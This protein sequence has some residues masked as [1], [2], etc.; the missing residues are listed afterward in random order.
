MLRNVVSNLESMKLPSKH[1]GVTGETTR[2]GEE[3][4]R[5][6]PSVK[7]A[8]SV[9]F[10]QRAPHRT[11]TRDSSPIRR[12][13]NHSYDRDKEPKQGQNSDLSNPGRERDRG[14]D[15][16]GDHNRTRDK[17]RE[18]DEER[19]DVERGKDRRQD[20]D[21]RSRDNYRS[22]DRRG[23]DEGSSRRSRSRSR[24][25]SQSTHEYGKHN[26]SSHDP[27][28]RESKEKRSASSNL[29]E[30]KDL[31]GVSEKTE[32]RPNRPSGTEEVIRLGGSSWR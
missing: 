3:T 19:R 20:Y 1:C 6:P 12:S 28:S 2:G 23:R 15:G 14:K 18:R 4:A 29:A 5:R 16:N 31:Y 13:V 22:Y 10:G 21:R 26:A 9:S 11:L 17:Y 25:R 30:L 27:F 24:S 8:L 32:D 7:A